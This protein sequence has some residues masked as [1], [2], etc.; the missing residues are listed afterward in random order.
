MRHQPAGGSSSFTAASDNVSREAS[1]VA[2]T[3]REARN[4]HRAAVVWLTGLS[5]AGKSTIARRLEQRLF[6]QGVQS[7]VLDG[8][9]LRHG[10]CG[11][12]GFSVEDRRENVRRVAHAARLLLD[13]GHVVICALISPLAEDRAAARRL[14]PTGRFVEVYVR[15]SLQ[16]CRRRDPKGLY[17]KAMRGEIG[18]FTGVSSPY[19]RPAAPELVIDTTRTSVDAAVARLASALAGLRI[20]AT[21]ATPPAAVPQP[22][23]E[24]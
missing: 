19:E 24:P 7:C 15:C 6:R 9:N 22:G 21:A 16:E 1:G 20:A 17:E 10:L 11:D 4:G 5:G 8:D 3:E 23:I 2:L 14:I 12:L 18:D 13:A